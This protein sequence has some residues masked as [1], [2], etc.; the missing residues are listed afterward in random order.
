MISMLI[1]ENGPITFM[2][3]FPY[4]T[5]GTSLNCFTKRFG[6]LF[7]LFLKQ[8]TLNSI[9]L[10]FIYNYIYAFTYAVVYSGAFRVTEE[11]L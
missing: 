6:H 9:I 11:D 3:F 8:F 10:L 7:L 4:A 1:N 2:L 5:L